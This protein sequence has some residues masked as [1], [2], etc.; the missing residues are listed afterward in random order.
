MDKI[1]V[2]IRFI[3]HTAIYCH[4]TASASAARHPPDRQPSKLT[5]NFGSWAGR[6]HAVLGAGLLSNALIPVSL[7]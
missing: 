5:L 3:L 1:Q 7:P 2:Q 4:L 6:L